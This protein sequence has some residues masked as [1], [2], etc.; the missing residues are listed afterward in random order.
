MPGNVFLEGE[1]VEL[2]IVE[3]EDLEF[4][5]DGVNHPEVRRHT[6]NSRP[7]NLED[8]KAFF[9]NFIQDTE[10]LHLLICREGE[11]MGIVSLKEKEEPS[12]IA[13]IGIWL[14]PDYHGQGYGTEAVEMITEH[15]FKQL[16][17]QKVY[18]RAHNGNEASKSIWE[19]LGFEK[20]GQLR[21]HVLVKGERRD[22][23]YYGLLRG[24]KE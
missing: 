23:V 21:E 20:E 17:Y 11:P 9:E 22:L 5:R 7:Q 8:E 16:N 6:G 19:K 24:E 4:L 1:Q 14:H 18:A 13:E 3:E 15:G 12:N 10:D 2:R